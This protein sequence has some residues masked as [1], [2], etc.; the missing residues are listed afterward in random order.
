MPV[1][2]LRAV[3]F[4]INNYVDADIERLRSLCDTT[5]ARYI[6][7]GKEKAPSTGTLHLQGYASFRG[8][9]PFETIKGYVGANAHIERAKGSALDNRTYCS[10]DG[11]F[12]EF[13]T[14]PQQ[15]SRSDLSAIC[16]Q[17]RAGKRI[18]QLG[19]DFDRELVRY[20]RG[21]Q[22]L[23]DIVADANP[24][25]FKTEVFVYV[26][27]P[28]VGKSLLASEQA[29]NLGSCYYKPNGAWWDG[30]IGQPSVILDDFYGSLA[31]H[32]LLQV[33]DR[34][35]CKVPVKGGFREFISRHIYITSNRHAWEWYHDKDGSPRNIDAFLRR[36][37]S[38]IEITPDGVQDAIE[39]TGRRINY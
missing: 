39:I 24:R 15:G 17:I 7:F 3:C 5:N 21:L 16:Q 9:H 38:Y 33:C 30:Y 8:Q 27:Q 35:P 32:E 6:I 14:I 20:H 10:K 22:V 23:Q 29:S 13:G 4:T 2:Y 19:P 25:T 1:G 26:G 12:E 28:G 11:N 36:V 31:Y 37:S 18:H 34:Y